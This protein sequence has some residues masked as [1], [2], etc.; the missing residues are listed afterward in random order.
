MPSFTYTARD[1]S[2][3]TVT[4]QVNAPS[5][6]DALRLLGARGLTPVQVSESSAAGAVRASKPAHLKSQ[7]SNLKS[8]PRAPALP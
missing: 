4:D 7:I 1:R 2:G 6:K 5:R 3:Q 8:P